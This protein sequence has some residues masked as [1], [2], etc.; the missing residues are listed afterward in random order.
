MGRRVGTGGGDRWERKTSGEKDSGAEGE[1]MLRS[2]ASTGGGLS[3]RLSTGEGTVSGP[4]AGS[5]MVSGPSVGGGVSGG[6][7]TGG[8]S[9]SQ[10]AST[11]GGTSRVIYWRWSESGLGSQ[12]QAVPD[13]RQG[14]GNKGTS[15]RRWLEPEPEEE[16]T[17]PSE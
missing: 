8:A 15:A 17:S 2:I 3:R 10:R 1:T 14:R 16:M 12:T 13:E 5:G 7:Y 6:P 11:G 9:S 4:A